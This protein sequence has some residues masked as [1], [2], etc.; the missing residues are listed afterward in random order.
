M[1][2]YTYVPTKA[3]LLEKV[4]DCVID[5][6]ALPNPDA[7]SWPD[8][9]RR[10]ALDAW[11]A[12]VSHPWIAAFLAR[13]RS[14]ERPAQRSSRAAL[15][16]LFE[17][18]GADEAAAREAVAVFFSYMIGSLTQVAPSVADHGPSARSRALFE[19]GLDIVIDGL[20]SRFGRCLDDGAI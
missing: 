2:V 13:Q 19:R 20:R 1:S 10:Y 16:R 5:A 17:H 6:V 8:E 9:M 4:V 18:A 11:D 3:T 7:D 12:Q 15:V 14:V